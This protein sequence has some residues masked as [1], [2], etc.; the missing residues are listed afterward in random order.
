MPDIGNKKSAIVHKEKFPTPHVYLGLMTQSHTRKHELV[1]TLRRLGLSVSCDI[2]M[3]ISASIG[4]RYCLF[5]EKDD[6]VCPPQI[7]KPFFTTACVDNI[8]HNTSPC[9]TKESFRST[10]IWVIQHPTA[11]S[12]GVERHVDVT[13]ST[14]NITLPDNIQQMVKKST[15]PKKL[16]MLSKNAA[17]SSRDSI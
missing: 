15:G 8:E 9:T 3:Y 17:A 14:D 6:V 16:I 1:E 10:G 2:L 13:N 5:Y 7:K 4:D 12:L 11:D